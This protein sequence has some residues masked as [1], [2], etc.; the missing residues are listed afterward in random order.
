MAAP[1]VSDLD[2]AAS[3]PHE[4]SHQ[5]PPAGEREAKSARFI[6][7]SPRRKARGRFAPTRSTNVAIMP[8]APMTPPRSHSRIGPRPNRSTIGVLISANCAGRE[9]DAQFGR[10]DADERHLED[11]ASV[12]GEVG[13]RR[14][15]EEGRHHERGDER[16]HVSGR[17]QPGKEQRRAGEIDHVVD[18]V[19]VAGPLLI[20]D[21]RDRAVEAV[22]KP[23]QQQAQHHK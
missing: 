19:A 6:G 7:G 11:A 9:Q 13:F 3:N 16:R 12:G 8:T 21:A 14:H 1:A 20:A 5:T 10:P 2:H 15:Q 23:V 17:R 4:R 22:A 18:V